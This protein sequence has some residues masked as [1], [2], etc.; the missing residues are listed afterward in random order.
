MLGIALAVS[1]FLLS[2]DGH[3]FSFSFF[4]TLSRRFGLKQACDVNE[5]CGE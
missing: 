4:F 1:I 2:L 3:L 5:A